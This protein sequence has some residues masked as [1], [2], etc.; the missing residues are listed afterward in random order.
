MKIAIALGIASLAFAQE[1][2][3]YPVPESAG[4]NVDR[5]VAFGDG[6]KLD[7]YR[8]SGE[9]RKPV[10]IFLNTLGGGA[11]QR[12]WT[13]YQGWARLAASRGFVGVLADCRDN[14]Q[15]PDFQALLG[16]IRDHGA[17]HGMDP[18]RV[19]AYAASANVTRA[20]PWVED[21]QQ[22]V[23]RAMIVYYGT[24]EVSQ[25]R[26]DLPLLMVRAGLDRP[27]LNRGMDAAAVAGLKANAPVTILNH[28]S[29]HHGFEVIDHTDETRAVIDQTLRFA[30]RALQPDYQASLR[31]TS[32]EA[33]AAGAMMTGDF[34]RAAEGFGAMVRSAPN[35]IRRH[36]AYGEALVEARRYKE[37]RAEFDTVKRIGGAGPRD[38][39]VPAARAAAL[40]G[41]YEA[42]IQWIDSIPVRFRPASLAADPAFATIR[43]RAEFRKL[44]P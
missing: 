7:L 20:L 43:D 32:L 44:F 19:A 27:A 14:Q 34:A 11:V 36:M 40:D 10:L 31:A 26:Q 5:D 23:I 13:I 12:G 29:G 15:Q 17:E 39:G 28:P 3:A 38:L 41:D 25:L 18:A 30:E 35:D 6:V 1:R 37:A 24:G 16:W 22:S 9:A 42:A 21:P 33:A 4:V 2:F 8:T